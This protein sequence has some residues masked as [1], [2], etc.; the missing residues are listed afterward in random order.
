M[1]IVGTANK[2]AKAPDITGCKAAC[3]NSLLFV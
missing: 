2:G 3:L 1:N